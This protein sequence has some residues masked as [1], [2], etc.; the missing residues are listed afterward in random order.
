MIKAIGL[1]SPEA[2]L[3]GALVVAPDELPVVD[4]DVVEEVSAT[5]DEAAA[6]DELSVALAE[7]LRR[8]ED[9]NHTEQSLECLRRR[10]GIR[11]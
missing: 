9:H 6:L 8:L 4:G 1:W 3:D 11:R 7:S 2:P 5:V 10:C